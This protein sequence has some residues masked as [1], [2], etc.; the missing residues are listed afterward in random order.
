MFYAALDVS[1]RSVSIC[2]LDKDGKIRFER[3]VA[4]TRSYGLIFRYLPHN[5]CWTMRTN[6][7]GS[8]YVA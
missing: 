7:A 6:A 5:V 1:Q 3:S 8:R 2:I 4:K